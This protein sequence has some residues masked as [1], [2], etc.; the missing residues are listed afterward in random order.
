MDGQKYFVLYNTADPDPDPNVM[1]EIGRI[2]EMSS[3][4]QIAS[5]VYCKNIYRKNKQHTSMQEDGAFFRYEMQIDDNSYSLLKSDR[6]IFEAIVMHEIGHLVNGDFD[7]VL[8]AQ[9]TMRNRI[10][11][12]A[13]NKVA[14]EELLADR[15]AVMQCGKDTVIRMLAHLIQARQQRGYS[16]SDIGIIELRMRRIAV[17][18]M[19]AD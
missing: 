11:M 19:K 18:R 17:K 5:I 12:L 8:D 1:S 3:N 13:Q 16:S 15:F 4:K 10:L 6:S 14:E 9:E 2:I 7:R